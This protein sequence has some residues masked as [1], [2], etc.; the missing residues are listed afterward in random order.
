MTEKVLVPDVGDAEEVTVVEVLVSVGDTISAEDSVVVLES[1][2]ASM[3][4]PSPVAGKVSAINVSEG[5]IVDEGDVILELETEAADSASD[6]DGET[7]QSAESNDDGA[8]DEAAT[9]ADE[10]ATE[11]DDKDTETEEEDE[12]PSGEKAEES[13]PASKSGE[14]VSRPVVVPD[15][16]D[17]SEVIV[18]EVLVSVGDQVDDKDSVCVLESDKASMEIPA[19]M[20]G[21]VTEISISEG[22]EVKEGDSLVVLDVQAGAVEQSESE[23]SETDKEDES[24]ATKQEPEENQEP[25]EEPTAEKSPAQASKAR[26]V[27]E[28][29]EGIAVPASDKAGASEDQGGAVSTGKVHAGPAVRKQAREYGVDL[30][31]VKG[32]GRKG[33]VLK[34]DVQ[35]Y[36]KSRLSKKG[37]SGIP[38]VPPVDFAKYGEVDHQTLSRVRK[39][40]ARNLHRSWLNVPHVTQFDEA[41]IT[42][43]ETFRRNWNDEHKADGVKVT[44][45]AF[46]IKICANALV[47]YPSFNASLDENLEHLII[48]RYYNIGIAVDTPDGLVVPVI[49]D[50]DKKGVV[51]LAQE[52]ADLAAKARDKKLP[53]DAMQ[54]AGFTISSL[55]GIGGT[56][57]T[58]IVNAPEVAIL[59]VSRSRVAP[60]FDGNNFVPRTML[61]LSLSYDHRAIDGAEAAR[62][63]SWLADALTDVTNVLM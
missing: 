35:Q 17:A 3:D 10:A 16:G 49:K 45:L 31:D 55:G 29:R 7:E 42:D 51:E 52:S 39:S 38:S 23:Q 18:V 61:P 44:P 37:D 63:T 15:V 57:F 8:A 30:A 56:A 22:Q 1:D 24:T 21:I 48:K 27:D 11:A 53:L 46:L 32:S 12:S 50:A 19:G 60:V 13:A 62:F 25:E 54:G 33:R 14:N 9:E 26:D 4:I 6:E 40:S 5:D 28:P 41:D 20:S 43:L 59:G 36:V 47:E 34:E 58:P 2:K